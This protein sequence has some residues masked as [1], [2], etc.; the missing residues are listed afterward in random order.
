MLKLYVRCCSA[1]SAM[2]L[3]L[4]FKMVPG[5]IWGSS[6]RIEATMG[7]L[8]PRLGPSLA[9]L[10]HVG[11]YSSASW[12]RLELSQAMLGHVEAICQILLGHEVGFASKH[13][14]PPA[15]PRF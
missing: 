2:L 12:A 5:S 13:V 11:S 8:G 1:M 10:D 7:I 15:G 4:C 14:S 6:A 3:D 9:I